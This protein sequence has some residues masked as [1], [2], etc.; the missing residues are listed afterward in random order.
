MIWKIQLA[1][2]TATLSPHKPSASPRLGLIKGFQPIS[3]DFK[4]IQS[5]CFVFWTPARVPRTPFYARPLTACH[6]SERRVYLQTH[7]NN[8]DGA[9]IDSLQYIIISDLTGS[10][11]R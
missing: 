7:I 3:K 5:K 6:W 10:E 1:A 9:M 8:A 2:Q 4:V 11:K